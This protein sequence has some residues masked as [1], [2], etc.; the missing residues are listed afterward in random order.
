MT[1]RPSGVLLFGG[2]WA[3]AHGDPAG[4]AHVAR[5]LEPYVTTERRRELEELASLCW[6]N[7]ALAC[8]RW[9]PLRRALG[10]EL[11]A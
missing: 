4:L 3:C 9:L 11:A 8:E 6:V 10:G 5:M 2:D 1:H 7:H